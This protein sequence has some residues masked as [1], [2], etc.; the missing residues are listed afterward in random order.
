M[1]LTEILT[2][3]NIILGG[4][5]LATL[6]VAAGV[7]LFYKSTTSSSSV[8]DKDYAKMAFDF[9]GE[10]LKGLAN[11]VGGSLQPK[12]IQQQSQRS[13]GYYW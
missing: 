13:L 3:Q 11:Y 12:L 5:F 9:S 8:S 7:W 10:V 6:S 4:G 2:P 1:N